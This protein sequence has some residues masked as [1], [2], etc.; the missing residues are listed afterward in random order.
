M[1]VTRAHQLGFSL[2]VRA[3][4]LTIDPVRSFAIGLSNPIV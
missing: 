1:Y 3:F 4:R 2:L